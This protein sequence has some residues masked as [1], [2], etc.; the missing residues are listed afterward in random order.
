MDIQEILQ[1]LKAEHEYLTDCIRAFEALERLRSGTP[2]LGRPPKR[3][4]D[5]T[6][7]GTADAGAGA[8]RAQWG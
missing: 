6:E 7:T 5:R 8:A 3:L 4:K 1:Q 2:K